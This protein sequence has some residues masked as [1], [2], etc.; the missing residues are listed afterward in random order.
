MAE[1]LEVLSKKLSFTEEEDEGI[2]IDSNSTKTTNEEF[3]GELTPKEIEIKWAPFWIQIFN[4]PLK[5]R[6]KEIGRAI[7]SKLGEVLEV[8]V[9]ES[10]VHWGRCLHVR[11]HI[12]VTKRLVR[13]KKI[14]IEGREGKWVQFKYE[15]L[16]NFCY[17]EL[18]RK[19]G[20]KE[21]GLGENVLDQSKAQ[22]AVTKNMLWE[23]AT[24]HE[25]T[26]K[27][28][29]VL[30]PSQETNN[31]EGSPLSL[32]VE[33]DPIAMSYDTSNGWTAE[34]LGPRSRHW[35]RLAREAK[36]NL[37]FEGKSPTRLKKEGPIPLQELDTNVNN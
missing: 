26:S 34:P 20:E 6:M 25:E 37:N 13:G 24:D 11:V 28:K 15:R 17:R 31:V 27:L 22:S 12:D 8:D 30:A 7:G 29:I 18:V 4:L 21:V 32:S 23:T 36:A 2:E 9:S 5:C 1:E 14:T 19:Q 16:P 35:K 10:G 3:D 33:P